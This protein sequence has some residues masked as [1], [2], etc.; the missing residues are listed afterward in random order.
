MVKRTFFQPWTW[1]PV[2]IYGVC[3]CVHESEQCLSRVKHSRDRLNAC[4]ES[5]SSL[6]GE[7]ATQGAEGKEAKHAIHNAPPP[8]VE[9][10]VF[11][12]SSPYIQ[13]DLDWFPET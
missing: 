9:G 6:K 12:E 10:R 13:H 4:R 8:P 7:I 1:A 5:G 3:W 2:S 11:K